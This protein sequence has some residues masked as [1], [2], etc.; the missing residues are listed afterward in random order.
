MRWILVG[1]IIACNATG[2]LLNAFGMRQHGGVEDFHPSGIRRLIRS[3]SR[4][5]YVVGGIIAMFVGFFALLSL[6]SIADLSFAIPATAGSYMIETIL[7]KWIL[8]EQV[9]W[10]RW[11]GACLVACGVGLLSLR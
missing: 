8:K 11:L 7:A 10:Q 5:R 3:I 6:L 9:H 2:D 1:I 4:N